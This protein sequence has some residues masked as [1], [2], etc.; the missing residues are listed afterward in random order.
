MTQR[1]PRLVHTGQVLVDLVMRVDALPEPGGD[2]LASSATFEVGGGFN[3]MAAARRSGMAVVYPGGHG[4]GRFGDLVRQALV[5]E[6]VEIAAA[7]VEDRDTGI[8]V[9]LVDASAER[10]FASHLGAEAQLERDVLERLNVTADDI[11]YVSGYSLCD[12]NKRAVL[13]DWL[14]TLAPDV[15]IAFDP[16]PLVGSIDRAVLRRVA[17]KLSIW[18]SNRVE[19]L[20]YA[21]SESI[22]DALALIASHLPAHALVIVRDSAAGCRLAHAGRVT[23]VP[24]FAVEPVDS[25]GAGDAHAGVFVASLA[26]GL[27]PIDAARR[28]NAAAALA[29]TRH[30]PATAPLAAE[31]DAFIVAPDQ[32]TP[33][34]RD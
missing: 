2:V 22:D 16:G 7:P 31:I 20:R 19:A 1:L 21:S 26:A 14:D 29:V 27:S 10:T 24:G 33:A 23:Q 5:R 18:T 32:R 15:R 6:G 28:A 17:A 8:C 30:G 9:A 12:A 4:R 3:V 11:V 34:S 13:L 25:N